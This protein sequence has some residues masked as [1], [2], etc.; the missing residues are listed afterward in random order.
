MSNSKG[1]LELGLIWHL[2]KRTQVQREVTRPEKRTLTFWGSRLWEG[3]SMGEL[4]E[5]M[6]G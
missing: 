2:N 4:M 3:R 1:W 6:D 5:D